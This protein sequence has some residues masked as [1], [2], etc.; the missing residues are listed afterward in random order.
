MNFANDQKFITAAGK[1][2]FGCSISWEAIDEP[3]CLWCV[4]VLTVE[5]Q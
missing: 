4:L 2:G 5:G 3:T 1:L